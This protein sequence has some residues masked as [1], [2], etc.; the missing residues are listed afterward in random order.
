MGLAFDSDT[1]TIWLAENYS[2]T[3]FNVALDGTLVS[4]TVFTPALAPD[5]YRVTGLAFDN[6][7]DTLWVN[8]ADFSAGFPPLD[9]SIMYEVSMTSVVPEPISSTLI[10]V[11]GATLGFRRFWKKKRTA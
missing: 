9:N 6:D 10:I 7:N 11:G 2:N 8:Y 4:S 5:G 3:L 1:D